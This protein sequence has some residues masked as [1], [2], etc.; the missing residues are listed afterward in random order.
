MYKHKG[1]AS[2]AALVMPCWASCSWRTAVEKVAPSLKLHCLHLDYTWCQ[3]NS[4]PEAIPDVS[5]SL[6]YGKCMKQSS[7]S[8]AQD[9][10]TF[11][12][13][14][15]QRGRENSLDPRPH[16]FFAWWKTVQHEKHVLCSGW[17]RITSRPFFKG[18]ID[19]TRYVTVLTWA[20]SYQQSR[21]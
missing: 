10:P 18:T 3:R 20:W 6:V 7:T 1:S 15:I 14:E 16:F 11:P 2:G 12:F 17:L 13:S 5:L 21:V 9:Q 8:K 4:I 19:Y